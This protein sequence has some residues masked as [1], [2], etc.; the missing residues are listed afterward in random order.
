MVA[1]VAAEK[2]KGVASGRGGGADEGG[3][4]SDGVTGGG[5]EVEGAIV[6]EVV[7]G[8]RADGEG[9]GGGIGEF[10]E[11]VGSI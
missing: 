1:E 6:E 7:G 3:E 10:A 2:G 5:E 11:G 9:E 8:E 4:V